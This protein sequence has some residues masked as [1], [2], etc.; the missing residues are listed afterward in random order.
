MPLFV[1]PFPTIDPVLIELGPIVI[2]WYALAYIAGLLFAWWYI[3]RLIR[4]DD[5]WAKGPRP[6]PEHIDDLM[7]WIVLGVIFGGRLGYVLVYDPAYFL[8][9]P[10][11]ILAVWQGGMSFHGGAAG[12]ILAVIGYGWRHKVSILSL[13]DLAAA[14]VPVG[15]FLGRLANFIRGELFGRVSDVPWAMVFPAGGPQPRHPSQL[16][17]AALE[18]IVLFAV[19]WVLTHRAKM[20]KTPGLIGAIFMIGY[21]TARIIV[22]FFRMPDAQIGFLAGGA[23]MG[24]VLSVP[25]ILIGMI[26]AIMVVRRPA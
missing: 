20:L 25:M 21:G 14:A 3:K 1:L 22:E 16:Y 18:G 12:V 13:L 15:L 10:G 17:E 2:R 9:N 11:A 8:A 26:L 5:L 19:L 6:K 23:T 7:F 4:N 24:M